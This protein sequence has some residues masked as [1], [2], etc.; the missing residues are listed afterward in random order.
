MT[1]TQAYGTG[2]GRIYF[3]E[4]KC[5]GNE[6]NITECRHAGQGN[7]NCGHLEDAAVLCKC[8]GLGFIMDNN[9]DPH[10]FLQLMT[11]Q[12]CVKMVRYD[13]EAGEHRL[14]DELRS[15]S[16]I[17]GALSAMTRLAKKKQLLYVDSKALTQ[18]V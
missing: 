18:K 16:M 12:E 1:R 10:C 6:S 17:D 11:P 3:D 8:N 13:S 2:I 4:V 9:F 14:M 7:H 15:V 5:A